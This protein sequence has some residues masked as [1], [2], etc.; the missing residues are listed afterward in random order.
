MCFG[1]VKAN[2]SIQQ[3]NIVDGLLPEWGGFVFEIDSAFA[4]SLTYLG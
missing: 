4:A 2:V 1:I 3:M